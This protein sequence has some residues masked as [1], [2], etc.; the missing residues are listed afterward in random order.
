MSATRPLSNNI[1]AIDAIPRWQFLFIQNK[2]NTAD[3]NLYENY[4]GILSAIGIIV[5]YLRKLSDN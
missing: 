4:V 5:M 1:I 2:E 3:Q